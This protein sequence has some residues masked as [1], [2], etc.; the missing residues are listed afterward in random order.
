MEQIGLPLASNDF[1]RNSLLHDTINPLAPLVDLLDLDRA[2]DLP[3]SL[4][5]KLAF[6]RLE[7]KILLHF[8][9]I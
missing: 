7:R 5:S 4:S 1:D 9:L 3:S 2:L 6:Y 8:I